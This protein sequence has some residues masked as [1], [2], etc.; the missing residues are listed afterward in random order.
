M[1]NR[2]LGEERLTAAA[3][4]HLLGMA[5]ALAGAAGGEPLPVKNTFIH[6][7]AAEEGGTLCKVGCGRSLKRWSTDPEQRGAQPAGATR[8]ASSTG[9]TTEAEVAVTPRAAAGAKAGADEAAREAAGEARQGR[10]VRQLDLLSVCGE[11][12]SETC[13]AESTPRYAAS[14]WSTS[15]GAASPE[16]AEVWSATGAAAAAGWPRHGGQEGLSDAALGATAAW[17]PMV[18]STNSPSKPCGFFEG[19]FMFTFTLRLARRVGLGID[20]AAASAHDVLIVQRILPRGAIEAWNRQCSNDS[21]TS[22]K[23]VLPGDALVIV[24]GK[25]GCSS[26]LHECSERVILKMTFLRKSAVQENS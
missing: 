4:A 24:N 7:S 14:A 9:G 6:F 3:R 1:S 22:A 15:A 2:P 5:A 16:G 23:A 21:L 13:S 26:V 18:T 12:R 11:E 25:V 8:G 10:A 20:V 17:L 19:A